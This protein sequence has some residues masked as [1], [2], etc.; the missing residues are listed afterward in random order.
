[1]QKVIVAGVGMTPFVKP[2]TERPY[3]AAVHYFE[4]NQSE[5]RRF[6]GAASG[7]ANHPLTPTG[8]TA[9]VDLVAA[10]HANPLLRGG[11]AVLFALGGA[12]G[13]VPR[14]ATAFVHRAAHFSVELVGIWEAPSGSAANLAWIAQARAVI[15]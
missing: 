1:M 3:D 11:G 12:V 9:L 5:K 15:T 4:G 6:I 14:P 13:K 10:R 2:G 7:Y 8:R